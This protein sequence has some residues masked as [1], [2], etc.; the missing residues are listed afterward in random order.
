MRIFEHV[1]LLKQM[2]VEHGDYRKIAIRSGVN[3]HWLSKFV[4][5][6]IPNPGVNNLAMLESFFFDEAGNKIQID[7]SECKGN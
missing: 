3:Y 2:A 6:R 4:C 1:D 5:D 7:L